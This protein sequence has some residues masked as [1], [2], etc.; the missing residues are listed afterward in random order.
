MK[1]RELLKATVL[2]SS[3]A[4]ALMN[5]KNS[6][7]HEANDQADVLIV[8][9][10]NAGIPAAIEASDMGAKV[11][12][13]DKNAFVGGMLIVSGGHISGANAKIQMRKNIKDSYEKHYQ[14]AMRI[15]KFK[16]DSELL[17]LATEHAASM[18]DW[19]EK[20]GVE[21][22][23]ESPILVD[24]HDH[25]SVPRTYVGVNLARSLLGPL[26]KELDKRVKRGGLDLKL[27]TKA[28]N[29]LQ[30]DNKEIIG[31]KVRNKNGAALDIFAKTVILASGGYG[32]NKDMQKKF[33]P[34]VVSAKWVGLP[35]ATGDGINMAQKIGANLSYMDHLISY[36]GTVFD[37]KGAP[38]EISTRLQFPPKHFTQSIWINKKGRR[39]VNEHTT[40][41]NREVAFLDQEELFFY[42]LFDERMRTK[43]DSLDIR[44]WS[45]KEMDQAIN[46]GNVIIKTDT[47]DQLA[48]K[49]KINP[50]R[51]SETIL[52]YNTA[53]DS[54][55]NDEF[56]RKEKRLKI[57]QPPYYAFGVGGSVL[58]THGGISINSSLEV[59][60]KNSRVIPGLYA[61]G[62]TIGNGHLMGEG[63][64][65]GMSVGPAIT[66]GRMVA[67]TAFR[68]AQSK[69]VSIK[70]QKPY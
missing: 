42:V 48:G 21:F 43:Q 2:G 64:V 23:D 56:G 50:K 24:D 19:L 10:G 32:A 8:G 55:H 58:N 33:N 51:L 62:E 47:I 34:K 37:L 20:I 18:V 36:P 44:N 67:K 61:I 29:L 6:N 30:D 9:A 35:H 27:E 69:H 31:V 17:A 28:L 16:A 46:E 11:I 65:S 4:L 5:T 22:T 41:D 40:P 66:F 57:L 15:G 60:G 38:T 49:L 53:I 14:D 68:Y 54:N 70:N 25:Y 1:R 13:I 7:A 59:I 52:K 63:V 12:L 3:A 26:K 39:F 45:S